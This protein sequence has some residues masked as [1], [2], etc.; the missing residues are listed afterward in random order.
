MTDD[1]INE[2]EVNL[3]TVITRFGK[4]SPE[5]NLILKIILITIKNQKKRK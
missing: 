2:T 1:H 4:F 3:E 5:V